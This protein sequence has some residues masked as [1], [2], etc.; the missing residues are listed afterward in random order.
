MGLMSTT[1]TKTYQSFCDPSIASCIMSVYCV[2]DKHLMMAHSLEKNKTRFVYSP[3]E[4]S[5]DHYQ[6]F[7]GYVGSSVL[8]SEGVAQ[9]DRVVLTG[10]QEAEPEGRER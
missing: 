1:T 4:P 7:E 2:L 9:V 10:G 3:S 6:M 5:G 8:P